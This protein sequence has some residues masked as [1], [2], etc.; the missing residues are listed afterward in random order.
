MKIV[1]ISD[2]H[3][4][5]NGLDLPK[6]DV[7]IHAGDFSGMGTVEDAK[8][9][10]DWYL[11]LPYKYKILICGNHDFCQS[12]IINEEDLKRIEYIESGVL[13]DCGWRYKFHE[14]IIYL[15]DSL[16]EIEGI[17]IYGTPW[18]PQFMN[19]NFMAT[20]S[21]LEEKF[22]DIPEGVDILVSHGP[23]YG[24]L[25]LTVDG[26]RMGSF[27]LLEAIKKVKPRFHVCGHNHNAEYPNRLEVFAHNHSDFPTIHINASVLDD[28]YEVKADPILT[29]NI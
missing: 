10:E 5:H 27:A 18:A 24:I 4:H 21:K 19:W 2:T 28:R 20:E 17:K 3:G 22:Q 1:L 9:F 29:I 12:N 26:D 25:D 15:E 14:D 16:V 6:G 7:I 13:L 8:I 11:N 23:A